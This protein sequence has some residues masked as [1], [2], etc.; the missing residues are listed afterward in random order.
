MPRP[1][2]QP[3]RSDFTGEELE[4]YDRVLARFGA[5]G[6]DKEVHPYFGALLNGPEMAATLSKMGTLIRGAPNRGNTYSH[7]DREIVDQ[8]LSYDFGY[9][10]VLP[11][12]TP[13]AVACGVRLEAIEAIRDGREEDL[14]D[15]ERLL[16]TYVREVV[17]GGVTDETYEAIECRVGKRGAAEYTM[18]I[19]YL[20]TVIRLFQAFG[21]PSPTKEEIDTLI[22]GLRD[23]SVPVPSY[24]EAAVRL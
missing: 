2:A 12:H 14:T 9:Y 20:S 4:A 11:L 18:F 22:D 5:A 13:D 16:V 24:E 17:G 1:P 6:E 7:H 8:V 23:G 21:M 15:E 3:K 19:A 10:G